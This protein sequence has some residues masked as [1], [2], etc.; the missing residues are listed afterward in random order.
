MSK[1]VAISLN[2]V[3]KIYK[4][5]AKPL[6]R[7]KE[8]MFKHTK[9]QYSKDYYALRNISFTIHC[10]ETVG[11]IGKNGA[12]KSTLLKIITGVLNQTNGDVAVNGI[13]SALLEL[14]AGFNPE[15][16]GMENIFLNG[17]MMGIEHEEMKSKVADIVAFAD[18][19]DFIDQPVKAY[20]SGMF[21]RLAFAV[22]ISIKPEILIVDEALSVGDTRFQIKCM[23]YMKTLMEGGT[24]VLFVSHDVNSIRRFCTRGIWMD[25]GQVIL[26][27]EVNRVADAYLDYLKRDNITAQEYRSI[28]GE[29][30]MGSG[31]VKNEYTANIAE[32]VSFEV[33]DRHGPV[34][35]DILYDEPLEIKVVYHVNDLSIPDPVIGVAI[36]SADDDYTCGLNTLLDQV[37]I[38]WEKGLNTIY[39][40]YP[41]GVRAAGGKYYFEVAIQDQTASVGIHYIQRILGFHM[42][43]PYHFEGRY[44]IPHTWEVS[45]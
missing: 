3:D 22:A 8:S 41:H 34:K 39:L 14:G 25:H 23:D 38:P 29:I 26:D 5:Y 42:I 18:I 11:I 33:S 7:L 24:T 27:G 9:K 40:H 15:Y 35:E 45:K 43:M 6:D 1:P 31:V 32:I 21:A 44:N 4:L 16:T 17:A 30:S 37:K 36:R 10:G 19:G 12:G 2:E 28:A 13:V 20:S